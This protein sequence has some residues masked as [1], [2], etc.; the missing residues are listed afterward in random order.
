[1]STANLINLNDPAYEFWEAMEHRRLLGAMDPLTRFSVLPYLLDPIPTQLRS[2][3]ARFWAFN[4]EKAQTDAMSTTPT[5]TGI[6]PPPYPGT[7]AVS[8][9]IPE[10]QNLQDSDLTNPGQRA[11]FQFA[12]WMQ[13]YLAETE[14]PR[15]LTPAW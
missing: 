5:W 4:H 2:P 12:N 11:W 15:S 13:H 6:G 10:N 3:A 7:F 9:T 1:M 14:L 8:V